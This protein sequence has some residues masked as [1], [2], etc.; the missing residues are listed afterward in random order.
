[1]DGMDPI[2]LV[3]GWSTLLISALVF[4]FKLMEAKEQRANTALTQ[5]Y[6]AELAR[7]QAEA[8]RER[9]EHAVTCAELQQRITRWEQ[10]ALRGMGVVEGAIDVAKRKPL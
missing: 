9:A 4:L 7:C 10:I 8:E 3:L 1:M 6:E 5:R 2:T